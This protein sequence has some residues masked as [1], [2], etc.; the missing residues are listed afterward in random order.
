[1]FYGLMRISVAAIAVLLLNGCDDD[2]GRIGEVFVCGDGVCDEGERCPDDCSRPVFCGNGICDP[3]WNEDVD[4]CPEDC[5]NV[6]GDGICRNLENEYN[7]YVDCG[8]DPLCGDHICENERGED[9]ENCWQ[10][11]GCWNGTCDADRGENELTCWQDCSECG[12]GVCGPIED[13]WTCPEDCRRAAYCGDLFCEFDE[14][15]E[16][17]PQDC[18]CG[19]DTCD[20][21]ETPETCPE[22]CPETCGDGDCDESIGEDWLHCPIDCRECNDPEF[23]VDCEDGQGCWPAGTNCRSDV[24]YCGDGVYRCGWADH[25]ANCCEDIFHSCPEYAPYF[26]SADGDCY[27]DLEAFR[28]DCPSSDDC[29][30]LNLPCS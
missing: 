12:N 15:A 3:F 20:L 9:D 30:S 16:T 7:C 1:M 13:E 10:D 14:T 4:N 17:C 26:C 29:T 21:D 5:E 8:P 19:W 6:C 27:D 25:R 2:D 11:C 22:D 24:F 23:P 18:H 28:S